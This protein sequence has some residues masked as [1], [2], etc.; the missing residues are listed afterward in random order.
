MYVHERVI[1]TNVTSM[2]I[3]YSAERVIYTTKCNGWRYGNSEICQKEN[4]WPLASCNIHKDAVR[5]TV[6]AI[7]DPRAEKNV[8]SM[9]LDKTESPTDN[10]SF[11]NFSLWFSLKSRPSNPPKCTKGEHKTKKQVLKNSSLERQAAIF[12]S[13]HLGKLDWVC[14]QWS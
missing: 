1:K 6:Q 7:Y 4:K 9:S 8:S 5:D 12:F 2:Q 11:V 14:S 13:L 3:I 10:A